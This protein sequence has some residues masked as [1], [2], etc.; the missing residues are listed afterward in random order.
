MRAA[1]A[2]LFVGV[3]A[4]GTGVASAQPVPAP[5]PGPVQPGSTTEELAEMVLDAIEYEGAPSTTA[6][7]APLP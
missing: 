7:P 6:V 1:M 2:G 4:S 5:P 3:T